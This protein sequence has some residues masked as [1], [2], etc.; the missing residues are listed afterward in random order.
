MFCWN[1]RKSIFDENAPPG[2]QAKEGNPFGPFWDHAKVDFVDDVF[3]GS[4]ITNGFDI[5]A[6]DTKKQWLEK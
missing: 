5:S 1:P 4:Q 6:K 2:C 3:F